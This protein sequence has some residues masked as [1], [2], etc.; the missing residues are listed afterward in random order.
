MCEKKGKD[1]ICD[2][3]IVIVVA[4]KV[5]NFTAVKVDYVTNV[6]GENTSDME[7]L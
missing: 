6:S 7:M 1:K 4:K 2:G 5:T 3:D